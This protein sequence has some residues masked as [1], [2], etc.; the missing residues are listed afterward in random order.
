MAAKMATKD[1]ENT[2]MAITS[3]FNSHRN[4]VLL[5]VLACMC[6]PPNSKRGDISVANYF[7][8]SMT[9]AKV[10]TTNMNII[11]ITITLFFNSLGKV[12]LARGVEIKTQKHLSINRNQ[13]AGM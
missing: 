10:T 1:M 4:V 7:C 13:I 9:V 11:K 3:L 8:E 2:A 12:L 5:C 6:C